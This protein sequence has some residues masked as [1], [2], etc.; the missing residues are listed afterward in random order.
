MVGLPH[1]LPYRVQSAKS[2]YQASGL[3]IQKHSARRV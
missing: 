3:P 2:L 1:N